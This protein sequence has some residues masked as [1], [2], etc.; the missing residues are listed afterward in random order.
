[1]VPL[2]KKRRTTLRFRF[3]SNLSKLFLQNAMRI[4]SA[5]VAL[6]LSL[7]TFSIPFRQQTVFSS[8][9]SAAVASAHVVGQKISVPGVS[10]AGKI[11]DSLY[12]GAQPNL[13]QLS[14]LKKLG[15]TTIVDL[16]SES[17]HTVEQEKI[18][19]ESL[20]MHFV[21][22]PVNGFAAPTSEQLAQFFLVIRQTPIEKVFV[23]CRF[24]EDRT[25]VFIAAY[26]IAFERWTSDQAVTE[27][28]YFGFNRHWHPAME[29]YVHSLPDRIH[30]DAILKSALE[31]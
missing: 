29:N 1:V 3:A 30:S 16:R 27:M 14:E 13:A 17:R 22:I 8:A 10:N 26:R 28:L 18:Q 5:I 20:G 24:G 4:F 9:P 19:A 7:E 21:S 6:S 25:G 31:N 15:V 12:R 2:R 23:H 11:S